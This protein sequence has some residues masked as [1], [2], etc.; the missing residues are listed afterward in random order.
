[1]SV[2]DEIEQVIS[3]VNP[4]LGGARVKFVEV[5][6]GAVVVQFF[7]PPSNSSCHANRTQTTEEIVAEILEDELKPIV[8]SFDKVIVVKEGVAE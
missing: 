5:K 1:M 2:E 6:S 3:R 4:S 8:P 7:D